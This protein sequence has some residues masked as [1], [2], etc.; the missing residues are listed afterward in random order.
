[1]SGLVARVGVRFP[2]FAIDVPLSVQPGEVVALLGPNGAG[3]TTLVLHLNGILVP[4]AGSVAVSARP[5][6]PN[7]RSTSGKVRRILSCTCSAF[8][9]SA[10]DMPGWTAEGM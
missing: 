3:K 4:S 9:A 2:G 8:W 10:T 1:M 6:L 5:A 7:T